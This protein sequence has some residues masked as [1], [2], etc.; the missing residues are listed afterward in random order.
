MTFSKREHRDGEQ[1]RAGQGFGGVEGMR[2]C[3]RELSRV[4]I[5]MTVPH[6]Y[7]C[8]KTHRTVPLKKKAHCV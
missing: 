2:E 1:R 4:L 5:V 7:A 8:A 3:C 6:I